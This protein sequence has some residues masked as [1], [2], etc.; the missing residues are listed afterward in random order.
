MRTSW[1]L[2]VVKGFGYI[3]PSLCYWPHTT[4]ASTIPP[5]PLIAEA[6]TRLLIHMLI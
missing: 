5:V 3:R 2:K 4:Q 6:L 1:N